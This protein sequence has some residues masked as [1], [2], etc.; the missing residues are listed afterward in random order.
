M[1]LRSFFFSLLLILISF[2]SFGSHVAGGNITWECLGGNQYRIVLTLYRDCG[3]QTVYTP[4][5]TSGASPS[6]FD[7]TLEITNSCGATPSFSGSGTSMSLV[8]TT[9]VSQLCPPEIPN[10]ECNGGTLPGMQEWVFE[11]TVTL[12]DCDCWTLSYTICCRNGAITNLTAPASDYATIQS[13]LCN[14]TGP[15]CNNSPSFTAQPIPYICNNVPICYDYGVV[16]PD[17]DNLSFA[18]HSALNSGSPSGY[19]GGYSSGAPIP[20]ITIDPA[21][22]QIC[23]T[24]TT[25][26]NFV[27]V[28]EVTETDAAG[29]VIGTYMQDIQFVVQNCTNN[30]PQA[31]PSITGTT[32]TG[33]VTGAASIQLCNGDNFCTDVVFTDID[34]GDLLTL[35]SNVTTVLPGATFNITGTNPAT[36]TIC[37][38]DNIGGPA[39]YSFVV[40]V[41]DDACPIPGINSYTVTVDVLDPTDPLCGSVC[42]LSALVVNPTACDPATGTYDLSG[43]VNFSNQ[44]AT[45]T[46]I[47]EDCWG[48]QDVYPVGSL[49]GGTQTYSLPGLPADG[50]PCDVTA[51]FSDDPTCTITTAFT[52]PPPCAP[53]CWMSFLQVNIGACQTATQTYDLDGWVD[54]TDPPT[55]GTLIIEDC[56]GNQDVYPVGSLS[57]GTQ[58][59]S[60]PGLPADGGPCD[61]IA[62]FSDDPACTITLSYTAPNPCPCGADAGTFTEAMTGDGNTN[63][64]L[65][66]GDQIDITS[67][68]DGTDP[69]DQ[70]DPLGPP[71]DPG[72]WFLV[73]TC[74]PTVFAPNNLFDATGTPIDPCLLGVFSTTD[75]F[76]TDINDGTINDTLYFVGLT[77]YSMSNG[78]YSYYPP[79]DLCYDLGPYTEVVYLPEITYTD[80]MNCT[81]G[82]WEITINGG[83]PAMDGSNFT[84][85]N[86]TPAYAS[87]STTTLPDGGTVSISGLNNGDFAT[88]DVTDDNGCP[89]TI[90]VGPYNCCGADAGTQTASMVGNGINNYILCDGDIINITAN[91]DQVDPND[92]GPLG[93][94]PYN[95]GL[96]YLIYSCPPTPGLDPVMDPCYTGYTIG[97]S[98]DM[99]DQNIGGSGGGLLGALIGLG[100]PVTNNELY[101]IPITFYNED[102]NWIYNANCYD[103]GTPVAVTYLEPLV[104]TGTEDCQAGTVT[105]TISGGYPELFPGNNYNIANTG[106]GTL[107]A[108]TL[109]TSGGTIQITGLVDGDM[110]SI[111][112]T[113]D[114]G[115]PMTFSGGPFVG[116]PT[117]DAGPDD[118]VCGLTYTLQAVPSV[119]TGT[120]TGTGTFSNANDPNSTVTVASAGTYTFT[121]TEDNGGGCT[122]FDQ[123]DIQFINLSITFSTFD[124]SCAGAC[125]GSAT[126]IPAGG[127]VPYT[128]TWSGGSGGASDP[129]TNGLCT[130]NYNLTVTDNNGCTIDT[131]N[132]PISGPVA[133]MIDNIVTTDETC[134][135]ACDGTI[136]LS[137]SGGVTPYTYAWTGTGGPYATEDLAG[138]CAGTYNITVTDDN[139]CSASGSGIVS[140]PPPIGI[141]VS[142]DTTICIGGTAT[143]TATGSGGTTPYTYQWDDPASS[144]TASIVVSPG[145]NTT[146]SCVITD[147][148]G[149]SSSPASVNVSLNPA[150]SVTALSDQT[151][152]DG[153]SANISAIANGGDGGPYT[154]SWDSGVGTGQNQTVSPATTTTYTVTVTDGC[155]TPSVTDA[156]TITVEALPVPTFSVDNTS[157]CA[158]VTVTFTDNTLP[159]GTNCLWDFGDGNFSTDC[160][161]TTY[162]YNDPGCYTVTLTLTSANGCVGSTTV[163]DMVC[164]FGYPTAE[165]TF[166][167]QPTTVLNTEVL[168][169]DQSSG[170]VA[171]WSWDFGDGTGTSSAQ[172]P[173][174]AFPTDAP[175]T[176]LVCLDV[177]TAEGCT[178]NIC[179]TV[180][181]GEELTI[182]VPNTITADG[183]GINDWFYPVVHGIDATD[184]TLYI[185]DRWGELIFESHHPDI[186][187]DGTYKGGNVQQ[188]VYVW[189]LLVKDSDTAEQFEYYGHVTVL[190]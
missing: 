182:Y 190:R 34:A 44:P 66:Y 17:G 140:S 143:L 136:D 154:Y 170:N 188:D 84:L 121:W 4:S 113:D 39:S 94:F 69:D 122:D 175:G 138:L 47:F 38:T 131:L 37:W 57:G 88:F 74:P 133:V 91:G 12:P 184:Y 104:V 87:F 61:V 179:H 35:T 7:N 162:T 120:W 29:N 128:Y 165:F 15:S 96:G 72:I 71:Y 114:N 40:D 52:A 148:N 46:L 89:I 166:G 137:A 130:G 118:Q 115:C 58:T 93:G 62:Y 24:P 123:V 78:I 81:A 82:T 156:V 100:V 145:A 189:K 23:F 36:A 14:S 152:C 124:E 60:I 90:T 65:C 105:V 181:I 144:T 5:I 9:E 187:W 167:P 174:Y 169:T 21:T 56:W 73:Y 18:L 149:C 116:L 6:F 111:T 112:V 125:D 32:G 95:P 101:Y 49:S 108:T 102:P 164:V 68:G 151:I 13:T 183:D 109:G 20:G 127:S 80:A 70:F 142:P 1:Q 159:A 31:P 63:F 51:Y 141:V 110:Y 16:E 30:P 107:S 97:S 25:I 157:G 3:G 153:S 11:T 117:A 158:P 67:N 64:V 26:G 83:L 185:F 10:S 171:T 92:V 43:S 22:G 126:V 27:V 119:G 54:F 76:M 103:L 19:A 50:A 53:S 45:G 180:I 99:T 98:P 172:N 177:A 48:N 176:Y 146:Y 42:N 134:A 86:L 161:T 59:Y 173:V 79:P 155:E 33:T 160:G 41:V 8:S 77:M 28:I 147:A 139:G 85:S 106:A 129:V 163:V 75:G 168:F 150:L 132:W 186:W 2:Q 178:D 135:G 55:T